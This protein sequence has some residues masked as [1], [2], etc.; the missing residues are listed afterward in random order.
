[1]VAI[2]RHAL[3][4]VNGRSG[5]GRAARHAA[6]FER[7]LWA[8]G[9]R[10]SRAAEGSL[11]LAGVDLVV[12]FGG[13][14]S[15]Q[16]AAEAVIRAGVPVYHVPS[17]N[18]NLFAR[19]FGMTRDPGRLVGAMARWNI[20]RIDVG[21]CGDTPFLIMCSVGPDAGVIH[22]LAAAR[23]RALG[24]A[25]YVGPVLRELISPRLGAVEVVADGRTIVEE[26]R[27]LVV[28]ANASPYGLGIDPASRASPTDGVLDVVFFPCRSRVRMVAWLVGSRLGAHVLDR[29]L[30]YERASS[31]R[32]RANG[33]AIVSQ[34]DGEA[35]G[36][37]GGR[38]PTRELEMRIERGVLPVLLAGG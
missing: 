29:E 11:E 31:V 1:M 21:R 30:V 35:G 16:H 27:G 37:F 25:A 8:A 28:V 14:G 38:H 13:D 34:L 2:A 3:F 26:S 22:R 15:L 4:V 12:F 32:V 23:R 9:H 7:A 33:S 6:R 5:R 17:G 20:A 10:V 36:E 18:E 24:H 19:Q